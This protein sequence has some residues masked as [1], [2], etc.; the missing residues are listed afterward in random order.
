MLAE[1]EE[2]VPIRAKQLNAAQEVNV[3]LQWVDAEQQAVRTFKGLWR[4]RYDV[5]SLAGSDPSIL[6]LHVPGCESK[7]QLLFSQLRSADDLLDV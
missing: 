7:P 4:Q 3:A 1:H 5:D 6:C 2:I